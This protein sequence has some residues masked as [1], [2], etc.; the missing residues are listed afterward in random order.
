MK[1]SPNIIV[2]LSDQQRWDVC[3]CYGQ[4]LNI[5]PN[6]DR[7][8]S[9][10]VRFERAFTC[11]PVCGPARACIQ[12]G[13][14]ATEIG[15]HINH[16]MLPVTER[17]LA[18]LLRE[19]GYD[20]AYIGKWHLASCGPHGGPDDFRT[21][22]VPPERRGGYEYWLASDVLE[23]T[24]HSYDG[25]MFDGEGRKRYFPE[26]RF[27]ADAQTDWVI[28]YL[29]TRSGRRPFFLFVSYLEPHHQNDHH[30]YEGP[31]GSK[32]RF[33]HFT[34]PG[35]LAGQKGDWQE[36]FPDYLGCCHSLDQN[37]G[38]IRKTVADLGWAEHTV[39][40]YTSDHGSHF[41]TRNGEYK[42]SCHEAS[43]RIPMVAFGPGFKGGMVARGLASLIDLPP[44]LL[45]CAGME[46]PP[47]IRGHPLQNML[48]GRA[49]WPAEVF[50]QISE[51]QCGRA[52]RTDR[53]KYS[54]RAPHRGGD[55]PDSDLYVEDFLYNLED[56]P[57]EL[58]NLVTEPSLAN[59]RA[60]LAAILRRRMAEI[61][62]P[63]CE[64][65]PASP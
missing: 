61:G 35:D 21:R 39:I 3:G 63:P 50:V 15:T 22:C 60:E 57:H 20:T 26:G 37:L 30:H 38:R 25:Y 2:I 31:T 10:G 64:I 32:E 33:K 7:M 12:T 62:E 44:T 45:V 29:K 17:T 13:K 47:Y 55:D 41:R 49:P 58:H 59:V 4:P 46:P 24:S 43:I 36:E 48:E 27:R 14:Y 9:E 8:A 40:F 28:E 18:H 16:R 51:S 5:T 53:W 34:P 54:V 6:L 11:Q 65:R 56:D 23:F 1:R 52:I 19:Q 42:R